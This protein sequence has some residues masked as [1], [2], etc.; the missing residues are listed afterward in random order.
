[1]DLC[2]LPRK[3][4]LIRQSET[5][6]ICV[7]RLKNRNWIE[8]R[9]L[10]KTMQWDTCTV[11]WP[12]S[13]LPPYRFGPNSQSPSCAASPCALSSADLSPPNTNQP[14]DGTWCQFHQ[15]STS[16]FYAWRSKSMKKLSIS[17]TL[18]GS[19]SVKAGHK[20]L[21]KLTPEHH[22][23]SWHCPVHLKSVKHLT[24]IPLLNGPRENIKKERGDE[25]KKLQWKPLNVITALVN[26]IILLMWSCSYCTI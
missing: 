5:I 3:L 1:V 18:S 25:Q 20:M 26:A 10:R 23:T 21:V 4:L 12:E 16:S 7:L 19:T 11:Q 9:F 24:E 15:R 2:G 13:I 14:L 22:Q 6:W 17:F 8:W